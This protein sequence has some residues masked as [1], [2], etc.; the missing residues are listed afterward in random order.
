MTLKHSGLS[1]VAALLR[2]PVVRIWLPALV[3]SAA[4][5]LAL[6]FPAHLDRWIGASALLLLLIVLGQVLSVELEDGSALTPTPALLIAGLTLVGWPLLLPAA[7]LASLGGLLVKRRSFEQV[8]IEA[9]SRCLI[10]GFATPVY[11][12]SQPAG[13]LPYSTPAGLLGLLLIGAIAYTVKLIIGVDGGQEP[14]LA[15]LRGR[16]RALRWYVLAMVPLGGLLGML[17]SLSPYLFLLGLAP[18]IVAQYLFRS[19]VALRRT[20]ADLERTAR[21]SERLATR[22]E[23][24][25]ALA[26]AMLGTLDVQSM[27]ELLCQRLA[28]LLDAPAGWV[29]LLDDN[30]QP[31]LMTLHNL[32]YGDNT[33]IAEPRSF[34]ALLERGR[35]MLVADERAQALAPAPVPPGAPDWSAVLCIPLLGEGDGVGATMPLLGAICLA[36]DRVRGLDADEQRVLSSFAHQAAVSIEN[37]R[38][39]DQLRHKQAELIQSSKLA[40]VGTFAAGIAHEFNNL[41]GSMLGYAELGFQSDDITDKDRSL[42]VVVQACR[43][44]RSITRGLLTF[45]RRQEHHRAM[46]D[47]TDAV[48]ETLTLV[49]IDLHKSR[50]HV[51]RNIEPIPLTVCDLGQLSQVVLNLITNARDAMRPAGGTLTISLRERFDRIELSVG[52]TG[53]GIPAELRDKIFEPFVTTKGALGGSQTPGTGLGLSVSYGIVQEHGGT[54][55][56][57]SALGRGTTMTVRLP[58]IT[59]ETFE[60]ELAVGA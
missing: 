22:V 55:E 7:L 26:T 32:P 44:G 50:I 48:N 38:L 53:S 59:A 34:L 23:R 31:Q 13:A 33:T 24:L 4:L 60:R 49:E 35:V 15:R 41:L 21:Q 58:I 17:W 43:R 19:A 40:A 20:S 52:D 42:E 47:I 27:L 3:I 54:I 9:G 36:F 46:A 6:G 45:A 11:L 8:L 5:T 39:F 57:E 2:L 25:Q 16:L 56:V 12:L 29:V 37:A 51:V 1:R 18:L 10:V 14:L 28:A 30:A